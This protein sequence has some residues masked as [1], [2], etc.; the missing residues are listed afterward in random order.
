M[1]VKED[2]EDGATRRIVRSHMALPQCVVRQPYAF[3]LGCQAIAFLHDD[4]LYIP[5][6]E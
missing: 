1:Q 2:A 6:Y 4:A 3:D 5:S